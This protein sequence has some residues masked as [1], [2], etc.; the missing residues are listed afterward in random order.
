MKRRY[1]F[2]GD[3]LCVKLSILNLLVEHRICSTDKFLR[4]INKR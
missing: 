3:N 2:V 1:S 4:I